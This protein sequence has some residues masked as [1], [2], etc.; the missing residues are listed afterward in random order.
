MTYPII[1]KVASQEEIDAAIRAAVEDNDMMRLPSHVVLKNGEIAG[2]YNLAS[3]PFVA[4]WHSTQLMNARDTMISL[5]T[6]SSI[7]NDR[8]PNGYFVTCNSKSP[9]FG[10][11]EK[12]G[13]EPMWPTNLFY[14]KL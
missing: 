4:C 12:L 13:Y 9:V 1:R 7:M 3:I 5:N 14:R 10:Y 2:A 8:F 11:M 6:M